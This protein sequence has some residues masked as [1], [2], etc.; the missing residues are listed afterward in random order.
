MSVS[1]TEVNNMAVQKPMHPVED[2]LTKVHD[3]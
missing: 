2:K 3:S 1:K